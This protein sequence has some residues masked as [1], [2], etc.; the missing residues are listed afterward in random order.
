MTMTR[1][2]GAARLFPSRRGL[3]A[4]GCAAAL[5]PGL[6]RARADEAFPWRLPEPRTIEIGGQSIAYYDQGSGPALVLVH[7]MSGSASFEWGRVWD[8]LARHYRVV[9]PFQI[10]FGP[11]AQPD[12][13]YDAE[14][15]VGYLGGLIGALGLE[16][17]IMVG[18]SFGGWV[19]GHYA[20]AQ[21]G[22]SRLGGTVPAISKLVIVDGA[23]KVD[24]PPRNGAN[25]PRSIN[26]PTVG[27]LAGAFFKDQPRVDNSLVTQRVV[28]GTIMA[29]ALDDARLARIRTPT[30]VMWG[31]Q[32]ELFPAERG[33]AYAK[34]IPGAR[35]SLIEDCGHIPSVEQPEAFLKALL[36]FAGA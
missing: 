25:Q 10:G 30:L 15:F 34:A 32:D 28:G 27:A 24:G 17:P 9:A 5:A 21:N 23:L 1:S 22:P 16:R 26:D 19:V 18:E 12:L 11:S 35:F 20:L 2:R 31:A 8:A 3:I 6:A 13:P 33:R 29:Q 4:A 7:G 36:A 14:T